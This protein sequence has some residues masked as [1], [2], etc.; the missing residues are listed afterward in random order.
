[1]L[2]TNVHNGA[3]PLPTQDA[4]RILVSNVLVVLI[5]ISTVLINAGFYV[6]DTGRSLPFKL[7]QFLGWV[8]VG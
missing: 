8:E 5:F 7:P 6:E 3:E 2:F 1:M 4:Y